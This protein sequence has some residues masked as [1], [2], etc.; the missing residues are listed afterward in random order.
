M[1]GAVL[2]GQA[3]ACVAGDADLLSS[4][5]RERRGDAGASEQI[6]EGARLPK[7]RAVR[8]SETTL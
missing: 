1:R 3:G 6:G 7:W 2:D 8:T 5:L 4:T